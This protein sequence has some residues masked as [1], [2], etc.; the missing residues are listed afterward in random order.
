M[1]YLC[2]AYDERDGIWMRRSA[3]WRTLLLPREGAVEVWPIRE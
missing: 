3:S 1:K 2:V